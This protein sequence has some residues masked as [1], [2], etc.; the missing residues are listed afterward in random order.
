MPRYLEFLL[1]LP[2]ALVLLWLLWFI[3]TPSQLI[4]LFRHNT[5]S[6]RIP[7]SGELMNFREIIATG[8]LGG[9]ILLTFITAYCSWITL[10][11]N[12]VI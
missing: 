2:H 11:M 6:H 10:S 1:N 4:Y 12:N 9:F 5:E 8:C 3:F 7:P